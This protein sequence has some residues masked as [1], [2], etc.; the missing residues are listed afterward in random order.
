M[1]KKIRLVEGSVLGARAFPTCHE[2]MRSGGVEERRAHGIAFLVSKFRE[3]SVFW[4]AEGMGLRWEEEEKFEAHPV[5]NMR[6]EALTDLRVLRSLKDLPVL[7]TLGANK[8]DAPGF[9]TFPQH[10]QQ[11][12]KK[13]MVGFTCFGGVGTWQGIFC[14]WV[15]LNRLCIFSH[16]SLFVAD[17]GNPLAG[18]LFS[19]VL[20]S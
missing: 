18:I 15:R 10:L 13:Q 12:Q 9:V 2:D 8:N 5:G 4:R 7:K 1:G 11:E 14:L 20:F 16:S 17:C 6:P 19:S 3:K